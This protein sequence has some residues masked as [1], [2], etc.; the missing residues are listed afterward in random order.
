L[1]P[2]DEGQLVHRYAEEIFGLGRELLDNVQGRACTSTRLR[3]AIVDAV[4]K[5]KD[6]TIQTI[7]STA[8]AD[9]FAAPKPRRR[10]R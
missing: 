10:E 6:P 2:T 4:P 9:I 3:V 8:R 7:F 1:V 5:L